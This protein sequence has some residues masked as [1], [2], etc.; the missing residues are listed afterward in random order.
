MIL[1]STIIENFM[2]YLKLINLFSRLIVFM[3][4]SGM[5]NHE[6]YELCMW[7][8]ARHRRTISSHHNRWPMQSIELQEAQ[9]IGAVSQQWCFSY[10]LNI[11]S[12]SQ[13]QLYCIPHCGRF[14]TRGNFQSHSNRLLLAAHQITNMNNFTSIFF[15]FIYSSVS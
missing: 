2:V 5:P 12:E 6:H 9:W 3:Q 13:F 7:L 11:S 10:T 8:N 15:S 1:I 4:C 14:F